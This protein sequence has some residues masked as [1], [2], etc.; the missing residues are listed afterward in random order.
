M[1][2]QSGRR[3]SG[4]EQIAAVRAELEEVKKKCEKLE[5]ELE[6]VKKEALDQKAKQEDLNRLIL[7]YYSVDETGC[8]AVADLSIEES[9]DRSHISASH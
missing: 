6:A 3:G 8:V 1:A 4:S 2:R 5:R 9:F 7:N